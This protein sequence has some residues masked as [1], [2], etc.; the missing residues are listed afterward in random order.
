MERKA[1]TIKLI[2]IAV[3]CATML[4]VALGL[5]G[6]GRSDVMLLGYT[7]TK[8]GILIKAGVSGS[9]GYLRSM[10]AKEI[11]GDVMVE[12]Y[13]TFGINNPRGARNEFMLKINPE[14]K[15]ILFRSGKD[16]FRAAL[17]KNSDGYWVKPKETTDIFE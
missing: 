12:F 13:S 14:C 10:K 9:A 2:S 16:S 17:I 15:R 3:L 4:L 1:N 8:E 6:G 7:E 11:D 5:F